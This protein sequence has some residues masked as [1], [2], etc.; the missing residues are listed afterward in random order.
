MSSNASMPSLDAELA[1]LRPSLLKFA[2]MQL[3]DEAAAEDVVSETM[4]A[5]FEKP[6][7]FEGRSSLRTYATGVLKHKIVD[8][9]RRSSREVAIGGGDDESTDDVL[10]ALFQADG[11]WQTMPSSWGD[12]HGDLERREFFEVLQ[13]CVDAMP[14]KLGRLFLMREWLEL[15]TEEICVELKI[16]SNNCFV[17]LFRARARLRECLQLNWIGARS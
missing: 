14:D 15:D 17:M 1:A 6:Q 13:T 7:A 12:P 2:R 3:R 8:H 5:M 9:I 16:S 10:D 4:I 11:H